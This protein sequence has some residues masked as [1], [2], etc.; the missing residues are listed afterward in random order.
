M[1]TKTLFFL[2]VAVIFAANTSKMLACGCAKK[3]AGD[4]SQ[5]SLDWQGRYVGV[6]PCEK[7]EETKVSIQ[8]NHDLTFSMQI[9]E[10]GKSN[11]IKEVKG[12]F[13]WDKKGQIIQLKL[14]TVTKKYLVGENILT[15]LDNKNKPVTNQQ[16]ERF[17]LNKL[18]TTNEITGKYW[19]L[20][21]LNGRKVEFREG[22]FSK[23]PHLIL[24]AE[25]QISG[26]GGCNGFHGIYD[27][28]AG[29]RIRF[30]Q[31]AST[32]MAC[33]DMEVE[34]QFF[35]IL[36]KVDNYTVTADGNYLSLNR[37]RMAPL[38]RFEVVYLR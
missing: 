27:L 11:E 5:N 6:E 20:I 22:G 30:S 13:F 29:H 32:L 8:I 18:E 35:Q 12:E 4:N 3:H 25:N 31:V 16:A 19:K 7:C 33:L 17:V 1:Q 10:V 37:A 2:L 15:L 24:R 34:E 26:H 28:Q 36:T 9:L 14:P 23:E 38:A 21:E